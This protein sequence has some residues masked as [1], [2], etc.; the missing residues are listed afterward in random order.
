[1]LWS[2]ILSPYKLRGKLK[3][4]GINGSLVIIILKR[5]IGG[6]FF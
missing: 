6:L 4:R 5:K 3:R 1:M 2:F